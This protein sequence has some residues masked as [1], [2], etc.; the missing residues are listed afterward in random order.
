[1]SDIHARGGFTGDPA[2]APSVTGSGGCCGNPPQ[3]HRVVLPDPADTA[4][5]PCCG[6]QAE[7]QAAG[8]CCGTAAKAEAVSSGQ[9]C[10]G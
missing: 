5:D 8:G 1:M 4:A 3:T 7:A 2:A 6:T 9:G 10:C